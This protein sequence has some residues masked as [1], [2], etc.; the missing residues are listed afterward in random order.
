MIVTDKL[1]T[2]SIHAFI[3]EQLTDEQYAQVGSQLEK[4]PEKV[5]EIQQCQIIN[6]RLR[7]VFDPVVLNLHQF[8]NYN[9]F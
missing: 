8:V 4:I 9:H 6:E 7:D 2:E 1:S 5:I 3:D